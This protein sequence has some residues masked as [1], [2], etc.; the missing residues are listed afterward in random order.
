M[1]AAFETSYDGLP[2][3]I[4]VFPL[5]RVMLL[6]GVQLPLNIFEPRYLAM[7]NHAMKHDRL[8]GM[9]QPREVHSLFKTGCAGRIA[10]FEE[11][12]DGR[13]LITLKGICRFDVAEELA[14]DASGFRMIKADWSPY[15]TDM[16]PESRSDMCREAIMQT[17]KCYLSKND[18]LCD[19]W[20]AMR[21]ISCEKLVSTLAVICPFEIEEK[22]A[23]LEARSLGDRMKILQAL[24]EN[25][26]CDGNKEG[27]SSCH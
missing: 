26:V 7:V 23:L 1:T 21:K 14:P 25:N 27:K 16:Q 24:L 8:I 22:Q 10:A 17:L 20:E 13:Y 2:A 15:A 11:T 18:M 12:E 4:P 9:I 19:Q 6:P 3:N 5:S